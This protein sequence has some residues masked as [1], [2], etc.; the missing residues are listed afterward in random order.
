MFFRHRYG[1]EF[2]TLLA[3]TSLP[4]GITPEELRV[5]QYDLVICLMYRVSNLIIIANKNGLCSGVLGCFTIAARKLCFAAFGVLRGQRLVNVTDPEVATAVMRASVVKGDALERHVATP[6]WRPLLSLESVDG[7]LHSSM[8][9]DF[10]DLARRLPSPGRLGEIATRRVTEL[11]RAHELKARIAKAAKAKEL[12]V[13]VDVAIDARA[14]A[15]LSLTVF[16]EYVF[17]RR[18]EPAFEPLLDA[19]WEWR[20]EIAVRGKADVKLKRIAVDVVVNDLLRK[21]PVLWHVHGEDW[22]KPRYY[23]LILQPYLVSPAI[24]VGD[25]AVAMA[26]HPNLS[27]ENAMRR[28]HPFP[29]FER[30]VDRDVLIRG[31]VVVRAHTQVIMFTTDFASTRYRNAQW[32]VFGAGPRAV[33]GDAARARD[34][35]GDSE[36]HGR[37]RAVRADD[38]APAL[39]AAQRRRDDAGGGVLQRGDDSA[40]RDGVARGRVQRRRGVVG[41]R[42]GGGAE[43]ARAVTTRKTTRGGRGGG[44]I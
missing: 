21:H 29:I 3:L 28:M 19:T 8:M 34:P 36:Q 42:G 33:R 5:V 18:W 32:P 26:R 38:R 43:R 37:A 6:A 39:G 15:R 13:D 27:L 25:I 40:D 7:E 12:G 22:A 30:Y 14:V 23:S 24:N 9:R 41:A 35:R 16:V 11:I 2:F 44:R 17:G 4:G 10:H 1:F 31:K 20:K